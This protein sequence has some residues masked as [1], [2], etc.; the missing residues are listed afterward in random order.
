MLLNTLSHTYLH[1]ENTAVRG[2]AVPEA[3]RQKGRGLQTTSDAG[4][5]QV[6]HQ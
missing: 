6:D 5:A 2:A 1:S 3:D 4:S